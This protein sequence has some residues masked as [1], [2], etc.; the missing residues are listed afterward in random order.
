V[1]A[2]CR[3]AFDFAAEFNP[4]FRQDFLIQYM[5]VGSEK[6]DQ[7]SSGSCQCFKLPKSAGRICLCAGKAYRLIDLSLSGNRF[8]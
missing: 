3:T 5:L 7:R 4:F 6:L 2:G 8:A 1:P